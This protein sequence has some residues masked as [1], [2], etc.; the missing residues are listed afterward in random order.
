MSVVEELAKLNE[1]KQSGA[2][3]EEEYARLKK[4]LLERAEQSAPPPPP[5]GVPPA[6]A[7]PAAA[8]DVNQWG[9]FIHLAQL[10]GFLV[11]VAGW[12]VPL[13]LW[14]LKKDESPILDRHGRIVMNWLLTELILIIVAIPLCFV[15][16]GIPLLVAVSIAGVVLPIIGGVKASSGVVWPYPVAF[17]FFAV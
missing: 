1:L 10:C 15:I 4:A 9:M 13:V 7:R 8:L 6:A 14:L 11:P 2:V 5:P 12:V 16:V 3:S 17:R